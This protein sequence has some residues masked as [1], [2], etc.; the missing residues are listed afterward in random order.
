MHLPFFPKPNPVV[1]RKYLFALEISP[2]TVKSAVW[3]VVNDKVQ[4]LAVGAAVNW[5][6]Q[7][8]ESLIAA[9][10][11]TLSDAASHLDPSGK[12]VV[13]EVIFGLSNCLVYF[14]TAASPL[15]RTSP[16]ML[17]TTVV[18]FIYSVAA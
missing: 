12:I 14:M 7:G 6:D 17:D 13:N 18:R 11:Q 2:Q 15:L 8:A 16:S 3:S 1:S 5:D 10:D 9:C 4:V